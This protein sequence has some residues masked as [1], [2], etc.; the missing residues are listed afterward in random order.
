MSF[1]LNETDVSEI[2]NKL[3]H[4]ILIILLVHKEATKNI[5]LEITILKTV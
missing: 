5:V 2:Y 1:Y 4:K 3:F